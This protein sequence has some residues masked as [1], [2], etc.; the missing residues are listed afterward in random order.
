VIPLP[1]VPENGDDKSL[2]LYKIWPKCC[3]VTHNQFYIFDAKTLNLSSYLLGKFSSTWSGHCALYSNLQLFF[4]WALCD[5]LIFHVMPGNVHT[6]T[7]ITWFFQWRLFVIVDMS[8]GCTFMSSGMCCLSLPGQK[9]F[10]P[11]WQPEWLLTTP[12]Q[13]PGWEGFMQ[14][15]GYLLVFKKHPKSPSKDTSG[16][17]SKSCH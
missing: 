16:W 11:V 4:S 12:F 10:K 9:P 15:I 5:K 1:L 6:K 14:N 8:V 2:A 13:R 3:L 17:G 7:S